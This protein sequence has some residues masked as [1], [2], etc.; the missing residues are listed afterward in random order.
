MNIQSGKRNRNSLSLASMCNYQRSMVKG[1]EGRGWGA[2]NTSCEKAIE[3]GMKVAK[4][5]KK[6]QSV[7]PS[8]EMKQ[9][10]R[11]GRENNSSVF[12]L[13]VIG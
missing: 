11:Q 4:R 6:K 1:G 2:I 3:R 13:V 8:H 9:P 5:K 10:K 7:S 12:L